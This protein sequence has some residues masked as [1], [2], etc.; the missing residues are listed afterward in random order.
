MQVSAN[1]GT[2]YRRYF[3][4]N[5][6][7]GASDISDP[8]FTNYPPFILNQLTGSGYGQEGGNTVLHTWWTKNDIF[9][10]NQP[11][12]DWSIA[13]T[14]VDKD[15]LSL[16][17]IG[18]FDSTDFTNPKY[19]TDNTNIQQIAFL[20]NWRYTVTVTNNGARPRWSGVPQFPVPPYNNNLY[21]YSH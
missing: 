18:V 4:A 8:D 21:V 20:N 6:R 3:G 16:T 19:K 13:Y 12:T 11:I 10:L 5:I 17:N 14:G 7:S 15:D 2:E 1:W 9:P